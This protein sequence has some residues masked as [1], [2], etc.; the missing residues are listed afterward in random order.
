[1]FRSDEAIERLRDSQARLLTTVD[2]LTDPSARSRL[3]GW[4]LGHLLTHIARNADSAVRRLEGAARGE[5]VDQYPGGPGG[6]AAEIEAGAFRPRHELVADVRATGEAV[7]RA[8]CALPAEAWPRP[9]RGVDGDLQSA[10][11]VLRGRIREVE[12][13]HVDLGAGYT[14]ADWPSWFVLDLLATELPAL[15]TRAAPADVLAWLIGR[16]QAPTLDAW[17]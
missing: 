6:R 17:R 11:Q 14:P 1:M 13:H 15:A 9:T 8:A 16:A 2:A 4:T 10:E 7:E 3:P 5:V 12:V